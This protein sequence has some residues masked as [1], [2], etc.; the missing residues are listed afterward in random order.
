MQQPLKTHLFSK[1]NG[2]LDFLFRLA[3]VEIAA[4][5]DG[6]M[7]M[8]GNVMY[9]ARKLGLP[10]AFVVMN[11]R[12]LGRVRVGQSTMGHFIGSDLGNVDFVLY[13]RAF[14]LEAFRTEDVNELTLLLSR[15]A[16]KKE[17]ILLEL[18]TDK[19]EVPLKLKLE[20]VY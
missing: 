4:V 5:G 19:D 10:I 1:H 3:Q 8:N 17:P 18:L 9:L 11:N 2:Q 12:S 7:L 6:G 13:A 16:E 14:G 15:A 20:G